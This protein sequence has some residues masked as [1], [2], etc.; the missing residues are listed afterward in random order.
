MLLQKF[1]IIIILLVLNFLTVIFSQ[2]SKW[3]YKNIK[4]IKC[5]Q[6]R[7]SLYDIEKLRTSENKI[8]EIIERIKYTPLLSKFAVYQL[9]KMSDGR[10]VMS[11]DDANRICSRVSFSCPIVQLTAFNKAL[12]TT[13]DF[14]D[15]QNMKLETHPDPEL[16]SSMT[17]RNAKLY[18]KHLKRTLSV[19]WTDG[20]YSVLHVRCAEDNRASWF[21]DSSK[22]RLSPKE[23]KEILRK[24]KELGFDPRLAFENKKC[25]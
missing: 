11:D 19:E 13:C 10:K 1:R 21:I 18:T 12:K 16:L 25:K 14:T 23:K 17:P 4:E 2:N 6:V 7:K 24:V 22:S 9:R 8:R 5:N 20:K 3:R 15:L